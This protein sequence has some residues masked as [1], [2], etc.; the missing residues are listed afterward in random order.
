[1]QDV[2]FDAS[3]TDHHLTIVYFESLWVFSLLTDEST[4][5]AWS[6]LELQMGMPSIMQESPPFDES[7][8]AVSPG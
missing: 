1:M 6:R 8:H 7:E 5:N 4:Y 3:G 2:R